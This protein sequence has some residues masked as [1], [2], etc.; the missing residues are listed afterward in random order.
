VDLTARL[1]RAA[2]K[3]PRVLMAVMPGATRQRLA[4]ERE[5][6]M[7]GWPVASTPADASVLLILGT[8]APG[9]TGPLRRTWQAVPVPR[10]RVHARRTDQ[11]PDALATAR[12]LLRDIHTQRAE[13]ARQRHGHPDGGNAHGSNDAGSNDDGPDDDGP[14]D[15]RED[16]AG[17]D[18]AGGRGAGAMEHGGGHAGHGMHDMGGMAIAGLAMAEQGDDRDGLRLDRLHVSWG[19]L[20]ADWP[21]GLVLRLTLQGDVIQDAIV[22]TGEPQAH[23]SDSHES[24]SRG[25]GSQRPG[26]HA[27]A[28][29]GSWWT[30]L[31]RRAALGEPV[32]RGQ[33]AT[34]RVAAHLDSLA[35]FL[36][37]AGWPDAGTAARRLRDDAVTGGPSDELRDRVRRFTSRIA[38]ARTLA[39]STRGLG[40]LPAAEAA[41]A[42]V[43]G[44]ARRAD[45][46][47]TA[48]YRRWLTDVDQRL[49]R[50]DDPALLD[51]ADEG[52]RGRLDGAA[53]PSA[54]LLAVLPGLLLGVEVG[55]A[56]LIVASLDPDLDEL[57]APVP[58]VAHG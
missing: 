44:P 53:P 7:R 30:E 55:A 1:L 47:V 29:E 25:P 31:W 40:T 27:G 17:G 28:T 45:G 14:N 5:L 32:T 24:T 39:W 48:R 2:S 23:A 19:P 46:D 16:P 49:D 42:G 3:R 20:L 41:A 52:P 22:E 58:E 11:V 13:A 26:S 56:R 6:R 54:A 4:A 43:T 38:R 37:V 34:R 57:A 51:P 12:R 35:R 8:E 18:H 21:T 15:A 10:A 50:W 9:M 33:A 36:A